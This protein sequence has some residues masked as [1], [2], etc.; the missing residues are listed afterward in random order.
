MEISLGDMFGLLASPSC[1]FTGIVGTHFGIINYEYPN[2]IS[3]QI[4]GISQWGGVSYSFVL[5]QVSRVCEGAAC[6][7]GLL[8]D[9]EN[10]ARRP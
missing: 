6:W 8:N 3:V 1:A 10:Y 4:G 9:M 7:R 5:F 2:D